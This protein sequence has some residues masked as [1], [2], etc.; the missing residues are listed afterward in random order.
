MESITFLRNECS[1]LRQII[2][3]LQTDSPAW[4]QWME[5]TRASFD[6]QWEAL[7]EG[8]FLATDPKFI[9]QMS[10]LIESYTGLPRAWFGGK[11]ILDAGCGNGRWSYALSALGAKVTAVDQSEHGLKA[12]RELCASFPDFQA[13]QANLLQAL[14]FAADSFDMLWSF[15]VL[16]HTGNTYGAFQHLAP[17]V[18]SGGVIFLML[19]GE[20]LEAGQFQEINAYTLHRRAVSGMDFKEKIAYCREHFPPE[21]VHG[22]FDAISPAI[23]DLYRFDEIRDW[24]LMAGYTDIVRTFENRNLF[25]TARKK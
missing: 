11:C 18:K 17:L 25:M 4:Q 8:D 3:F 1:D 23:N 14:P 12:A 20:P 7:P 16:H 5:Q 24:L 2:R 19:Y 22:W 6:T 13:Q 21:A 15:G 9:A 10:A